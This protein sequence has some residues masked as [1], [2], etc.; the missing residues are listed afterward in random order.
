MAQAD[1]HAEW[2]GLYRTAAAAAIVMAAI[3][4]VQ[5]AIYAAYPPPDTVAGFF[6]L[7]QRH[8]LLGLLSMDLL[9]LADNALMVPIYLALYTTLR[10]AS[11]SA[12]LLAT[13]AALIG[14]AAYYASNTAFEMLALSRQYA[15]ATTEAQRTALL[16]AGEAMLAIYKGTAFNV[17]Y[18]LNAVAL[19]VLSFVMLRSGVFS[20]TTA[21]L[22]LAAGILMI[23][24]S[25][26]GTL[27]LIFAFLSLLPWAVWLILFAL[28]LL[29]L[30]R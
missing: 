14:L 15:L 19:L 8:W 18:V 25:T 5:G 11:R 4:P 2:R 3:I 12:T 26:A 6:E 28:R 10:W 16:G 7:F 24:P 30:A 27:G 21:F 1:S 20:K 17:Y 13:A 9:Y 22:G 23:V 29:R